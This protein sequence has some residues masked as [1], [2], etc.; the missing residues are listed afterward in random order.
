M[1]QSLS[2]APQRLSDD[3][4]LQITAGFLP[5]RF[6][7]EMRPPWDAA[8]QRRF[9]RLRAVSWTVNRLLPRFVRQF[10]FNVPLWGV[11]RRIRTGRPLV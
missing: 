11:D 4:S 5:Q 7:D 6:R 9:D 3:F 2:P 8:K 10:P 1:A